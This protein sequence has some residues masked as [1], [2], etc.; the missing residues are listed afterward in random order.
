MKERLTIRPKPQINE[1]LSSFLLRVCKENNVEFLDM[2][3]FLYRDDSST[4][5]RINK[6][7]FIDVFPKQIIKYKELSQLTN[8]SKKEINKMTF[9][10]VISKFLGPSNSKEEMLYMSMLLRQIDGTNRWFCPECIKENGYHKLIWQ[11]E[12]IEICNIHNIKLHNS[13]K[14][15]NNKHLYVHRETPICHYCHSNLKDS[16]EKIDLNHEYIDWQNSK[17]K[18]W[19]FLLNSSVELS[20]KYRGITKEKAILLNMLYVSQFKE[21]KFI[22]TKNKVFSKDM[23]NA[24]KMYIQGNDN[25]KTQRPYLPFIFKVISHEEINIRLS[26]FSS[27]S[28]PDK[29]IESVFNQF[30][31]ETLGTCLTPWCKHY[32]TNKMMQKTNFFYK[33]Y[34]KYKLASVCTSCFVKFGYNRKNGKW[35]E[36]GDQIERIQKV[37]KLFSQDLSFPK[38]RE[39]CGYGIVNV[40]EFCG[41][42]L[43]HGLLPKKIQNNYKFD[44]ESNAVREC[45]VKLAYIG[46]NKTTY[47]QKAKQLFGWSIIQFYY[48]LAFPEVQKY[49]LFES[50][51]DQ[52]TDHKDIAAEIR[53]KIKQ[54]IENDKKISVRSI[55]ADLGH[56]GSSLTRWGL[57]NLI[58]EGREKQIKKHKQKLWDEVRRFIEQKRALQ[59]LFTYAG[60]C[61]YTGYN[62]DYFV[63]NHYELHKYIVGE[64]KIE[65]QKEYNVK[66]MRFLRDVII[67]RDFLRKSHQKA[68]LK[69]T[70]NYLGINEQRIAY[71]LRKEGI[72]WGN[73][74]LLK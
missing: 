47:F 3:R 36:I 55:A 65:K 48:Y 11:V 5:F 35:E 27:I 41:Y 53:R 14:F 34:S 58:I 17:Y 12:E 50:K 67:A 22:S 49:F 29:Y 63:K 51:L 70:A 61:N 31:D 43:Y 52:S 30:K 9:T 6:I 46:T 57:K 64:T 62:K 39:I 4:R 26:E 37:S 59:E 15:C 32:N 68:T 74:D 69:E 44:L 1:S 2:F 60:I 21:E 8:L 7:H 28:V 56:D 54:F 72:K 42:A 40:Y 20:P 33:N 24:F 23:T 19:E 25:K 16:F 45:F 18:D 38:I 66:R 13:C 73:L 71:H 10:P